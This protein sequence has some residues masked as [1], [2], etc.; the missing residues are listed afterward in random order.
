MPLTTRRRILSS[1][2]ATLV[3]AA[4]GDGGTP[5]PPPPPIPTIGLG[6]AAVTFADTAG[7][8][9][10]A[11]A[12]VTVS[13]V[14]SL[15]LTGLSTGTIVYGGSASGWLSVSMNGSQAPV[16]LTL[17]ASNAGL[18]GGTYTATVPVISSVASNSPANLVVT[19]NVHAQL[20]PEILLAGGDIADCNDDVDEATAGILDSVPGT[21]ATLG[22]NAYPDGSP[23]DFAVCFGNSW[24]RHKARIKPALGNHEYETDLNAAP[25]FAYFGSV[26]GTPGKGYYSYDLGAWHIIVLNSNI[27]ARDGSPQMQWLQQDLAA[28]SNQCTLAYFHH[29]RFTSSGRQATTGLMA[30]AVRL[31][32]EARAEVVLAAH[33]H[34]YERFAPLNPAGNPDAARG[35]RHFTVGLAGSDAS[36]AYQFGTILATSESRQNTAAGV[37]M[38]TLWSDRYSWQY[39]TVAGTTF[40]DTGTTSCH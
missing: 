37:L 2:L 15:D 10:P 8:P 28:A 25:Y 26:A 29:P 35:I 20:P 21:I 40:S 5:P 13:N 1:V 30:P 24:G 22:D 36:T 33:D 23:Q 39:L 9:S 31:L 4:C 27:D 11:A 19:Y 34:L 18:A 16:T 14:G 3:A 6:P 17:T 7:T 38:L 12:T 32:Y